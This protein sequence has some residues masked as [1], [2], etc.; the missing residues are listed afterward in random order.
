MTIYFLVAGTLDQSS[1]GLRII[2]EHANRLAARGHKVEVVQI[3]RLPFA[4][5]QRKLRFFGLWLDQLRRGFDQPAWFALSNDVKRQ[6]RYFN[7]LPKLVQ[8]DKVIATYFPTHELLG[9]VVER[10]D[11]Y[12]LIQGYETFQVDPEVLHRHWRSASTNLVISKW[13]QNLVKDIAG[14]AEL[15]PNAIDQEFFHDLGLREAGGPPTVLFIS[16][17][18]EAKGTNDIVAALNRIHE[19]GVEFRVLSFGKADPSDFGLKP[20]CEFHRLPSQ[21]TIREL[22]SRAHIFVGPSHS[23]GWGLPLAEATACGAAV[24]ASDTPGHFEFLTPDRDA[25]FFPIRDVDTLTSQL[26]RMIEDE[27][28]RSDLQASARKALE[29]FTWARATDAMETALGLRDKAGAP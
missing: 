17:P 24:V 22:Y 6:F 9:D 14:Q 16:M 19:A 7:R 2:L 5:P 1:G 29:P 3:Y 28:L 10:H 4:S 13:L 26:R 15:V 25:L 8:G 21:D 27:H 12:S 11:C 20:E 23:E 18:H